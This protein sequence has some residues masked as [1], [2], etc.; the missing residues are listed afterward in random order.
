MTA[1]TPVCQYCRD[2][3]FTSFN[4]GCQGCLWRRN[5][6]HPKA[7]QQL[8]KRRVEGMDGTMELSPEPRNA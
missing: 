5:V 7:D 2:N 1:Y 3:S 8:T 6:L 4:L